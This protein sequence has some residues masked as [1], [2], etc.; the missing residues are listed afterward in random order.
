M[1]EN[2]LDVIEAGGMRR[3]R[4]ASYQEF[5]EPPFDAAAL[6]SGT[7]HVWSDTL[8]D[9][10]YVELAQPYR[11]PVEV[12]FKDFEKKYIRVLAWAIMGDRVSQCMTEGAHAFGSMVGRWPRYAWINKLPKGVER[13]VEVEGVT[14]D[15][16]DWALTG[17][18]FIG[19]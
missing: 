18:L 16:A 10:H 14:L 13:F 5:S 2:V 3:M 15:E 7:W 19:G 9:L 6:R 12:Y 8:L 17:F 1:I 4:W 11:G